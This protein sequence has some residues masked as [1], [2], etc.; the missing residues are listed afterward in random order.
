MTKTGLELLKKTED[1]EKGKGENTMDT[2]KVTIWEE[3]CVIP[4]YKVYPPEK[5]PLF[6]ENLTPAKLT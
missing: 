6:I 1:I 2:R 5:N 4:T 3:D